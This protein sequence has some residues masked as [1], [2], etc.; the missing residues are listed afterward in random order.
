MEVILRQQ[1]IQIEPRHP[2]GDLRKSASHLSGMPVAELF[3]PRI[4]LPNAASASD[5][6]VDLLL[7]GRPHPHAR[8]VV[9]Q[10]VQ[11]D[12]V[13]DR[14]PAHQRMHA[15]GVI[16]NHAAKCA[17]TVS[18]GIRRK[19]EVKL[20]GR[21]AH[22]VEHRTRLHVH[23]LRDRVDRTD[24]V[25]VLRKIEN[26][27]RIAPLPSQRRP[28]TT[29]QNRCPQL[30]ANLNRSNNIV[31]IERNH[32]PGSEYAGSSTRR[33]RRARARPHRSVP[34][35]APCGAAQLPDPV[36]RDTPHAR[37]RAS[38]EEGRKATLGSLPTIIA[39][40]AHRVAT[41]FTTLRLLSSC[42]ICCHLEDR[43]RIRAVKAE[44]EAAFP[45]SAGSGSRVM[46]S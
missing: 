7:A 22:A 30:A 29:R 25:H 28:R 46:N 4:D 45:S 16:P 18:C 1:L 5:Q 23:R 2:S 33:S 39:C 13:V 3:K 10:H 38:W 26:N 8:P 44:V 17:S 20:F 19:G 34:P 11:R 6:R 9:E 40:S 37:A 35:R 12:D 41:V 31:L 15:A 14:L 24:A 36:R 27:R 21:L 32:Q 42:R 43:L